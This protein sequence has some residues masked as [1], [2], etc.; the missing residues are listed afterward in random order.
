MQRT[1]SKPRAAGATFITVHRAVLS[2]TAQISSALASMFERWADTLSARARELRPASIESL[3]TN[4]SSTLMPALWDE[5]MRTQILTGTAFAKLSIQT[6]TGQSNAAT[7]SFGRIPSPYKGKEETIIPTVPS[8]D[9]VTS[10]CQNPA[11]WTPSE[12]GIADA[13][14]PGTNP[15]SP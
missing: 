15:N 1:K 3:L 2:A 6:Q 9:C 11:S 12:S 5:H 7:I 14:H 10:E 8:A 4:Q 13:S